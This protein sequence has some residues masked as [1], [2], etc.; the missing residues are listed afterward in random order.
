M[1]KILFHFEI[2][3]YREHIMSKPNQ[4]KSMKSLRNGR[5]LRLEGLET[6]QLLSANML[7]AMQS[8]AVESAIV[9]SETTTDCTAEAMLAIAQQTA[10][11]SYASAQ[12]AD[13]L[14]TGEADTDAKPNPSLKNVSINYTTAV[15]NDD[16]AVTIKN[17]DKLSVDGTKIT[18]RVVD[19]ANEDIL[20]ATLT[21]G[22]EG[23]TNES[24]ESVIY[25][26]N[27]KTMTVQFK[28][29][30]G[31]KAS[32]R[33]TIT[34]VAEDAAEVYESRVGKK[35]FRTAKA[36]SFE[37]VA[38][39][40]IT[41]TVN[42]ADPTGSVI[43]GWSAAEISQTDKGTRY[44]QDYT[45]TLYTVSRDR[46]GNIVE[47][48]KARTVTARDLNVSEDGKCELTVKNLK[49]G[50]EYAATIK[51]TADAGKTV[52]LESA[53][54]ADG[55][56]DTTMLKLPN[57]S[58][59]KA[60]VT[61][62]TVSFEIRNAAKYLQYAGED[63]TL[64]AVQFAVVCTDVKTKEVVDV[65]SELVLDEK[66]GKAFLVIEGTDEGLKAST[67][68]RFEIIGMIEGVGAT[69]VSKMTVKTEKVSYATPSGLAQVAEETTYN[70]MKVTWET[71]VQDA[72]ENPVAVAR[73]YTITYAE[74]LGENEDGT[75]KLGKT[76]SV[77]ASVKSG[78][79]TGEYTIRGLKANT[80]YAVTIATAKDAYCNASEA[81][82]AVVM[83]TAEKMER[84]SLS[85]NYKDG[86][87]TIDCGVDLSALQNVVIEGRIT[88][89]AKYLDENGRKKSVSFN[90]KGN[91]TDGIYGTVK[92]SGYQ[93]PFEFGLSADGTITGLE[94]ADSL[95][96][97]TLN[98]FVTKITGLNDA[99]QELSWK[100][101]S[102]CKINL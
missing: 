83:T 81:A 66:S 59:K 101:S 37:T 15:T 92:I 53:F 99:G 102:N 51:V 48:K 9:S 45:V 14:P 89:S 98:L 27:S 7:G 95:E 56:A 82:E 63:A 69:P 58:L 44:A 3:Y 41:V 19:D 65:K 31:M 34:V 33:Y 6:R 49:N 91:L 67:N 84:P 50:T 10:P 54:S 88:G 60:E 87:V 64:D 52:S 23:W 8:D 62:S 74:V 11:Q 28:D 12:L 57:L 26:M 40:E 38:A 32:T 24:G 55:E 61:D 72:K 22:E 30:E 36:D 100:G 85:Y 13:L 18:I 97:L 77:T 16:L 4:S 25:N 20:E 76:K 94:I 86:S 93:V 35:T 73:R 46:D 42:E 1:Q 90:A 78:V 43:V 75:V 68:Y 5:S 17:M 21:K 2:R 70:T 80:T 71:T 79:P 39:D 29:I 47:Y 96:S